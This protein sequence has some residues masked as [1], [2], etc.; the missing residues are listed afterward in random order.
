MTGSIIPKSIKTSVNT[1]LICASIWLIRMPI[2]KWNHK[3]ARTIDKPEIKKR[4]SELPVCIDVADVFFYY[5]FSMSISL[6]PSRYDIPISGNPTA[7]KTLLYSS[8]DL[9]S[10]KVAPLSWQKSWAS[11]CDIW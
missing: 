2:T 8:I 7:F 5:L 9:G 11:K 3:I 1:I 6:I 10:N 4:M